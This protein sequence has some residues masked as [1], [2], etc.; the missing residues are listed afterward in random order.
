MASVKLR[1]KKF[2]A[3]VTPSQTYETQESLRLDVLH[4]STKR[5]TATRPKKFCQERTDAEYSSS[6]KTVH[7]AHP[8]AIG[9]M[10]KKPRWGLREGYHSVAED[11]RSKIPKFLEVGWNPLKT[12]HP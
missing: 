8:V 3:S 10:G 2:V 9:Q 12:S 7:S 5:E 1:S 4:K 6:L 11:P